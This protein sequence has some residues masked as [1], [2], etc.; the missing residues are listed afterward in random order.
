MLALA[1]VLALL[2]GIRTVAG[3][4]TCFVASGPTLYC[5]VKGA[6]Y[7]Q[8]LQQQCGARA[9]L[10]FHGFELTTKRKA[11]VT[12]SGGVL[13]NPARQKPHYTTV[14]YGETWRS[15]PFTCV[16]VAIRFTCTNRTGHGLSL[17]ASDYHLYE[18]SSC[19]RSSTVSRLRIS[20]A[21]PF[22]TSTAAGRGTAL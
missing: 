15:G 17:S 22:A 7:T 18:A 9:G 21:T 11:A 16:P 8:K 20:R 12:C 2:P 10:D 19:S 4:T 3:N 5:N 14:G 6:N 1:I 13:Y